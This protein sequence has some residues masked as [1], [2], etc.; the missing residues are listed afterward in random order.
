MEQGL[1]D[2]RLL[3]RSDRAGGIHEPYT[4][5]HVD[6]MPKVLVDFWRSGNGWEERLINTLP[7]ADIISSHPCVSSLERKHALAPDLSTDLSAI[8]FVV[9]GEDDGFSVRQFAA[10]QSWR[11]NG[12]NT[13]VPTR[14]IVHS[15][16]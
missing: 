1:S 12:L 7:N 6:Q 9:E 3:R 5:R 16:N 4:L 13:M 8:W 10:V 11:L 14:T 15:L 2:F